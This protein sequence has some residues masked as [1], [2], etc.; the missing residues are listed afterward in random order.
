MYLQFQVPALTVSSVWQDAPAPRPFAV[1]WT[2]SLGHALIRYVT[3]EV[4]G[5]KIDSQYGEWLNLGQKNN[6]LKFANIVSDKPVR[7]LQVF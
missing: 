6:L 4:G 2:N 3:V 7:I 5:Q 1:A